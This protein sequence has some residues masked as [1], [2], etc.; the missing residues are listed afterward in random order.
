MKRFLAVLILL[1]GLAIA[2]N[3]PLCAKD[4]SVIG[5]SD[6]GGGGGTTG[7]TGPVGPT[8]PTGSAGSNGATGPT[9]TAGTNGTNGATGPTGTAGTN[10]TN[11]ATGPTGPTGTAGTN[12]TNGTNGATGP[13][14]PTGTAGTNGTNGTNGATG[15]TGPTGTAGINGTNGT[16]GATGPTGPTGTA[17]ATGAT[18]ATGAGANIIVQKDDSTISGAAATIDFDDTD[19][20]GIV[21]ESPVGEANLNLGGYVRLDGRVTPQTIFGGRAAGDD[22]SL[23]GSSNTAFSSVIVGDTM[24]TLNAGD[25]YDGLAIPL[26]NLTLA[27]SGALVLGVGVGEKAG[28]Q[29]TWTM[30][31]NSEGAVGFDFSPKI[32][33]NAAT[34][35][36]LYVHGFTFTPT[37]EIPLSATVTVNNVT[38]YDDE[39]QWTKVPSATSGTITSYYTAF[40]GPT[41]SGFDDVTTRYGWHF[42]DH[43]GTTGTNQVEDGIAFSMSDVTSYHRAWFLLNDEENALSSTAGPMVVGCNT[44]DH[45]SLTD[46][47]T[48]D[49]TLAGNV[50]LEL[51]H[52]DRAL[53]ANRV[54]SDGTI[55]APENGMLFYNTGTTKFRF[56]ENGSWISMQAGPLS[57]DVVTSG[58][59]ATI[60][61]DAVA[62]GTDT[63]GNYVTSITNGSGITGGNGGSEGAALT[64][65]ATLGTSIDTTEIVDGTIGFADIDATQTLAG[66]P[67]NGA[68]SVWHATTGLIFEGATSDTIEGLLTA[69]DPTASDKT[70]TLPNET[71]TICTTGSVC[72]GYQAGALT[73]DVT[74]S[75]A[76]ATLATV[77]SNVGSFGTATQS[78]TFTVNGKGLI[79]AASNTTIALPASAITSG[80]L[81]LA[82]GGTNADLS[83][84]GAANSFLKQSSSGAAI[85]VGTIADADIPD[86]ITLTN[87]TQIGTRLHSSL[88]SLSADD[89]T[90]YALLAGRAGSQTLVGGTASGEDII[91]ESTANATKGTV[92]F[93]DAAELRTTLTSNIPSGTINL[94]TYNQSITDQN[95]VAS[96]INF[97]DLSPTVTLDDTAPIYAG[98]LMGGTWTSTA[99]T[100]SAYQIT[101]SKM[102]V[103]LASATSAKPPFL[104]DTWNDQSISQQTANSATD[105]TWAAVSLLDQK[106]L[107]A[108]GTSA[109]YTLSLTVPQL[110]SVYSQ[111]ELEATGNSSALSLGVRAAVWARDVT[112]N[113][114][115]SPA[116]T[117]TLT[118]NT[119]LFVDDMAATAGQYTVTNR[120]A[121]HSLG[122]GVE[123]WLAGPVR[124]GKG[125]S[126][127]LATGAGN[128]YR[129]AISYDPLF[130]F[131]AAGAIVTALDIGQ[132]DNGDKV[133]Q[134]NWTVNTTLSS[135]GGGIIVNF[136]PQI[137]NTSGTAITNMGNWTMFRNGATWKGDNA[138]ITT[139]ILRVLD[140]SPTYSTTADAHTHT[141][142][143]HSVVYDQPTLSPGAGGTVTLTDRRGLYYRNRSGSGTQTNSITVDADDQTVG[144]LAAVVRSAMA[145]G[146]GKWGL[147]FTGTAANSI[148]GDV[149]IGGATLSPLATVHVQQQTLG[150]EVFRLESI[151]T[152]DDPN[153]RVFQQRAATTDTTTTKLH[154]FTTA[155]DTS[156]DVDARVMGRCTGGAGCTAGQTIGCDIHATLKNVSGTVTVVGTNV[157]LACNTDITGLVCATACSLVANASPCATA[158]DFCVKVIGGATQNITWHSLLE[159]RN[160][161]S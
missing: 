66:N 94:L 37:F 127:T 53:L 65:A 133:S 158:T 107:R 122:Y 96:T 109:S 14:G 7:P 8:G 114:S 67:A 6:G 56:R 86:T 112:T 110:V 142:T 29:K 47:G 80:Q 70:W 21:T 125:A 41:F 153:L 113:T 62:L 5:C 155:T 19:A 115:G 76:A 75:G 126:Y 132:E 85:T 143:E 13:T 137:L 72:A 9:G 91:L 3:G 20:S 105:A 74:T 60:Q 95:G 55:A 36:G 52:T 89:H 100:T 46:G 39:S 11:G 101:H 130:T 154:G 141:I 121:V 128:R 22:L 45:C 77:N 78:G 24:G 30:T 12:G 157:S 93:K 44:S 57:G 33:T 139:N 43:N 81:A 152:N 159:V 58:A 147:L 31:G 103:I 123:T 156:Y 1:P 38:V 149:S 145:S 73:G 83:A 90:Q 111:P 64:L 98:L 71:G 49:L 18:G 92:Q 97:I 16:N 88:T 27:G 106:R 131:N 32:T 134:V 82:R 35:T 23:L 148:R 108:N 150:N 99:A 50:G 104:V 136:A 54:A 129:D 69:A 42:H 146:S 120:L 59:V 26:H 63:T 124:L 161:A 34:R 40:S 151:A 25:P 144:T 160:L 61:A 79:T 4:P 28:L 84:T 138:N 102:S 119:G 140:N 48:A 2:A 135:G 118:E 87:I 117:I 68:N 51:A 17:G 10:G 15:P 116:G